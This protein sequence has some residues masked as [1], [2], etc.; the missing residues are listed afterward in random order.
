MIF[1][2]YDQLY[3]QYFTGIEKVLLLPSYCGYITARHLDTA[4]QQRRKEVLIGPAY[5][6]GHPPYDP[7]RMLG[8][9]IT[10]AG[11][12]ATIPTALIRELYPHYEYTDLASHPAVVLIPYQGIPVQPYDSK[13]IAYNC[14]F[15][16]QYR[17]WDSSKCTEWKYHCSFLLRSF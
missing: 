17:L 12:R 9:R 2:R 15:C 4:R 16:L 14:I 6:A 5:N 1:Y 8:E 10:R 3:L 13:V 11:R 7:H